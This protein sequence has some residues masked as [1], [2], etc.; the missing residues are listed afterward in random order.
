MVYYLKTVIL[1]DP[2]L[3]SYFIIIIIIIII[4]INHIYTEQ[5]RQKINSVLNERPV[6]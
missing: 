6:K 4:I 3:N 1:F 5:T 2:M